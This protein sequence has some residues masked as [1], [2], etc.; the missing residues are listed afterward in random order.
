MAAGMAMLTGCTGTT[1][2]E[3][4]TSTD[5]AAPVSIEFT[6][7]PEPIMTTDP[8]D[9]P[10]IRFSTAAVLGDR[11]LVGGPS[12]GVRAFAMDSATPVWGLDQFGDDVGAGSTRS[13]PL[14]TSSAAGGIVLVGYSEECRWKGAPTTSPSRPAPSV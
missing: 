10:E 11:L 5:P 8:D 6:I 12:G 4:T 13:L 1:T 2:P 3:P 9:M 7:A 14:R